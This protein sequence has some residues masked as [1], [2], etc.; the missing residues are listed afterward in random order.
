[1][2]RGTFK[3]KSY[4]EKIASLKAKQAKAIKRTPKP[5]KPSKRTVK[6]LKTKNKGYVVP[7]WFNSVP[8]GSHGNTPTLKRYWKATSDFIRQRDFKLYGGKCVSCDRILADWREGDCGHFKKYSV[9]NA[10]FKFNH[11]NLALQCK[12]C[13]QREDGIVGHAFGESLKQRE[14]PQI[15][16]WIEKTNECYRG[17]KMQQWEVVEKVVEM[18]PDLPNNRYENL[19]H[20][21]QTTQSKRGNSN[22][23]N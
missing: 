23:R 16:E 22:Q 14:H 17:Q 3:A 13:N 7:K 19:K 15:I 21:I 12:K 11:S 8:T 6:P 2:K 4:D 9:C 10:W 20:A 5:K 18:W 1:M